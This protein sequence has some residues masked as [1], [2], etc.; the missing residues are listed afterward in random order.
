MDILN[1]S[2]AEVS[3]IYE[4]TATV[5]NVGWMATAT[6]H[7]EKVLGI[8]KP[9]TVELHLVNAELL[10]SYDQIHNLGVLPGARDAA[11]VEKTIT[12]RINKQDSNKPALAEI[13]VTSEKA[14]IKRMKLELKQH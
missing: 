1:C 7:A 13:V 9:V 12:W 3:D 14:G 10:D 4:V 8:A 2:V 11:P 5:A 6:E